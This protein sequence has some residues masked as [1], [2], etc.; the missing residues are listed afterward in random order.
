MALVGHR[1]DGIGQAGNRAEFLG[2]AEEIL[3]KV[4]I[5]SMCFLF[6]GFMCVV[7]SGVGTAASQA[8]VAPQEPPRVF[9]GNTAFPDRPKAPQEVLDHGKA[10]YGVSC[11][12]CHGSDAGGGEGGPNLLRSEVVLDDQNGERIAPI[13]HGARASQG[14]PPIDITDVQITDVA[15][16]LH[17][18]HVTSRS[19][20]PV[21]PINIVTGNAKE[22]EATFHTMCS[23]CHSITGDLK[24]F[25]GMYKDPRSMQ[26]AWLMP[27][28]QGGRGPGAGAAGAP[29][30]HVKP[31]TVTVT[32]ANGQ[33]IEGELNRIDDFY[34]SLR[35]KDGN[36]R[37]FL[38]DGDS[39]KVE[40]HDPLVPHKELL[41]KYT[42]KDMHDLTAY[43]VT[44]K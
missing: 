6:S 2:V 16:W 30:L 23:S 44:L 12:F 1:V 35:D 34:I 8:P 37:S 39:P 28:G 13:V 9:M 17:S 10:V 40:I 32:I 5:V 29:E 36:S 3:L 21:T 19:L 18:I 43:L 20:Q 11:S 31:A 33:K 14:M 7:A 42:D 38:R 22:G 24:G 41:R 26:Q 27:G 15:A 25:A 4:P